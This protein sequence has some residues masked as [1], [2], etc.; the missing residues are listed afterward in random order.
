LNEDKEGEEEAAQNKGAKKNQH[1]LHLIQ[2][3]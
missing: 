2:N 3:M 1:H